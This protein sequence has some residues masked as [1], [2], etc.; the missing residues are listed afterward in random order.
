[1]PPDQAQQTKKRNAVIPVAPPLR[2]IL[3]ARA[4]EAPVPAASHE[5]AWA[6]EQLRPHHKN[7]R[8]VRSRE[9]EE[10]RA[11]YCKA[12]TEGSQTARK[13]GAGHS[14]ATGQRGDPF[15]VIPKKK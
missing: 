5:T 6:C 3:V 9:I 10:S 2:P 14:L 11:V 7:L 13:F 8:E 1:M 15:C 4:R 12:L